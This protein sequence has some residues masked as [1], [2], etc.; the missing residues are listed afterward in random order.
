[1]RDNTNAI[2]AKRE[3]ALKRAE[4]EIQKAIKKIQKK[5]GKINATSVFKNCSLSYLTVLKY[6]YLFE[7]LILKKESK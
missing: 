1:M 2:K 7:N 3:N 6:R 5:D 4:K